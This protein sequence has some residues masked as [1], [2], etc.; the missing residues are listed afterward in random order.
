M[1]PQ[2]DIDAIPTNTK[3]LGDS[4]GAHAD[5]VQLQDKLLIDR[6]SR[7]AVHL[8]MAHTSGELEI[9]EAKIETITIAMMHDL[10]PSQLSAKLLLYGQA[11]FEIGAAGDSFRWIEDWHAQIH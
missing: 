6:Q 5:L 9:V 4:V 10:I 1:S 2:H 8:A 7:A 11:M 3:L